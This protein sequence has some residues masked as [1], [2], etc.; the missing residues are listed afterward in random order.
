[1][2]FKNTVIILTSNVG[3]GE[4]AAIEERRDLGSD[5][6]DEALDRA[7]LSA[8]RAQFRPEFL[9]R[10]DE[11]VVYRR[12]KKGQIRAIVDI[13]L[14]RLAARLGKRDLRLELDEAA[15][16]YLTEQGWDPQFGARPLKRAIQRHLED[17]LAERLLA[18]EFGPGSLVRVTRTPEG[19]GFEEVPAE[20]AVPPRIEEPPRAS[21]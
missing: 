4:L 7:A 2:D 19:L 3:S 5:E 21:A 10:L 15:K 1:V 13:Q 11:I 8:L 12:L 14:G 6:M 18:G 16:D 20:G 17:K 9:N